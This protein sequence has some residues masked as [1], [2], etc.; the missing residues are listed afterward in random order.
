MQFFRGSRSTSGVAPAALVVVASP[1]VVGGSASPK[2][3]TS[4][5]VVPEQA[6]TSTR[7]TAH[8]AAPKTDRWLRNRVAP[9][10]GVGRR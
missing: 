5:E 1:L 6:P 2:V 3:V 4:E 10:P 9:T 8:T 7:A